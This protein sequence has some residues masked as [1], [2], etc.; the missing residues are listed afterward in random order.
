MTTTNT[1]P[2]TT[3]AVALRFIECLH[4][5]M[6]REFVT[7]DDSLAM[8]SAVPDAL[9]DL[10]DLM[11]ERDEC[12]GHLEVTEHQRTSLAAERKAAQAA[13]A[14]LVAALDDMLHPMAHVTDANLAGCGPSTCIPALRGYSPA[15]VIACRAA[16]TRAREVKP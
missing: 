14:E 16:L 10:R 9:R 5:S 2:T 4:P 11:R 13:I 12:I 3:G 7:S 15:Q 6:L 1:K 8:A